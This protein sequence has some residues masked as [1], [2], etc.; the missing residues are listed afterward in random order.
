MNRTIIIRRDYLHYIPK[1]SPS[2]VT[3]F[4][5]RQVLIV[6]LALQTVTKSA[7]RTWPPTSPPPSVLR[8]VMLSLLV[9]YSA[10]LLWTYGH[11][12]GGR[13]SVPATVENRSLQRA[14]SVEEQGIVEGLRKVLSSCLVASLITLFSCLIHHRMNMTMPHT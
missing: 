1:Y 6:M 10:R 7:T 11:L 8:P 13:R 4:P 14:A 12:T 5:P 9:R 3:P 2:R